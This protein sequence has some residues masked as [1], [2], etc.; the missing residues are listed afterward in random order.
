MSEEVGMMTNL[1]E[2]LEEGS[3]PKAQNEIAGE[4]RFFQKLGYENVKI[5]DEI[6]LSYRRSNQEK[7]QKQL[8]LSAVSSEV[9]Q[10]NW[11]I[12]HT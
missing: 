3:F 9:F 10:K 1:K 12:R 7:Y 2:Q 4:R 6:K 11:K 8:L 5:G